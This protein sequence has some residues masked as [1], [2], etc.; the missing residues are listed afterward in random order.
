[1]SDSRISGPFVP[2]PSEVIER[3]KPH[4]GSFMKAYVLIINEFY[5]EHD[6]H[7]DGIWVVGKTGGSK[8]N[9]ID[10]IGVG[11]NWF[12]T[13]FWPLMEELGLI[14]LGTDGNIEIPM[15][16]K[17]NQAYMPAAEIRE[18]FAVLR[19]RLS[20]IEKLP[21]NDHDP[22]ARNG[23]DREDSN[24]KSK[25]R[26]PMDPK[27][28]SIGSQKGIQWIP[29]NGD[30]VL[31]NGLKKDK[32]SLSHMHMVD[33]FYTDIGQ[34]KISGEKRER[35]LVILQDLGKDGFSAE[36]IEFGVK[37][38]LQNAKEELYDFSILKHTIGQALA[39]R[40]KVTAQERERE[41]QER[42][43]REKDERKE[44]EAEELREVE[45]YRSKLSESEKEELNNEALLE[46]RGDPEVRNDFITET[47]IKIWENRIIRRRLEEMED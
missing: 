37:W 31:I 38:I 42:R 5:I 41:E 9:A 15:M 35:A 27:K 23:G 29:K 43:R 13:K 28:G 8:T 33:L 22:N 2:I 16:Y 19:T 12:H 40:D 45:E 39:D 36:D 26:D 46:L 17:K 24:A 25:K 34:K 30:S 1:M 47:I 32:E 14:R 7:A 20:E 3:L 18:E 11:R 4:P 6:F 21:R 10:K 44:R